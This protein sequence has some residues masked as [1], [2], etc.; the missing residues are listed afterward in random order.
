MISTVSIVGVDHHI[1]PENLVQIS[2]EY[3]F[4]EW[5]LDIKEELFPSYWL[6]KL[7]AFSEELRLRGILHDQWNHDMMQGNLSLRVENPRLWNSLQRIQ[8]DN[9]NDNGHLI[10]CIQLIQDKNIIL[11]HKNEELD[12]FNTCL[13]LPK[14]EKP[15]SLCE[16]S[17]TQNEIDSI[18]NCSCDFWV[19][20][21]FGSSPLD[22]LTVEELLDKVE[23]SI[24]PAS[25]ISGLLQTKAIKKRLSDYPIEFNE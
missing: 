11:T 12:K 16:L 13:L 6:N 22:L 15:C 3:P 23:D 8:V 25:W 18:L 19:S 17:I 21:D 9:T 1:P 24:A 14:N 20:V 4:V 10:D 2:R 7:L 5:A